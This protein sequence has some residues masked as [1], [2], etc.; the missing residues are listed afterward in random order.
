[1]WEE[2]LLL[3]VLF[4]IQILFVF[5]AIVLKIICNKQKNRLKIVMS[6]RKN[7]T[8]DYRDTIGGQLSI[9]LISKISK[10][11]ESVGIYHV[12]QTLLI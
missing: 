5:G 12:F 7:F 2:V 8:I 10:Y 11:N 4:K 1:M 6:N 3:M 9:D